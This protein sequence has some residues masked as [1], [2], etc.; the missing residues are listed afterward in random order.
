[1]KNKLITILLL[2]I[3]LSSSATAGLA[4]SKNSENTRVIIG[5]KDLPDADLVYAHGGEKKY[6]YNSIHAIAATMPT[7]QIEAL[8]RDPRVAYVEEDVIV[9][10]TEYDSRYDWGISKIG[11]Q[12]VHET[13]PMVGVPLIPGEPNLGTDIKVAVIDTGINYLHEDL[14]DNIDTIKGWGYNFLN[15]G[16]LP[17]DDNGHGTHCA[18]IIAAALDQ[19]IV[20]GVA[21]QAQ[22]Y[23]LKVLDSSGSGY[24][25][26]IIEAI[27][28]ACANSIQVISMSLGASVGTQA[29]QDACTDAFVNHN[30]VVVAAAGNN[31]AAR[32]G[33]NILYPARYAN[34]IAVGATD[35]NNVRAYFSNTGPE[36]DLMAPGV[37]I[38]SDYIDTIKGDGGNVDTLFMSGTSMATPHVA[39]TAA[40]ILNSNEAAWKPYGYTNGNGTWESAE[41]TNVL[42]GTADDLGATGKDN[43]Y[44]YGIVDADHAALTPLPPPVIAEQ[45]YTPIA[46]TKTQGTITGSYTLL[47]ASDDQDLAVKSA[48]VSTSQTIDWYSTTKINEAPSKV[49]SLTITYEG[50]YT[51]S[52]SQTLYLY[53]FASK[54]WQSINTQTVSTSDRTITYSSNTPANYISATGD[55]QLR[56]Y[57]TQRTST[58]FT[59]N[60]DY[61]Q[62]SIKYT[63]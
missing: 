10:A 25:S 42:I 59:C 40:L 45:T 7:Q 29:L 28:W 23:A 31:G 36:L 33:T 62:I 32:T 51:S 14:I 3:M 18:G 49:N 34:V 17:I 15:P 8:R 4:S 57:A 9:Q 20:V 60:A 13:T 37:N 5:F 47:S 48:K 11:A 26:D 24:T 46:I 19:K 54:T 27:D 61:T 43:L 63:Q 44:G 22:L 16:S 41:V 58:S 52:K 53:N 56:T 55:I 2:V 39:G 1:L 30:I 21:P 38:L 50:S 6:E 35:S 12:T